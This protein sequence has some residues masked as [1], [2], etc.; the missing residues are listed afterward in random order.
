MKILSLVI[1]L[2]TL[3]LS[4]YAQNTY[5]GEVKRIIDGDTFEILLDIKHFGIYYKH[6]FRVKNF[7]APETFRPMN[8]AERTHGK[9]ATALAKV[10]LENKVIKVTVFNDYTYARLLCHIAL[11][12]GKDFALTMKEAGMQKKVSYTQKEITDHQK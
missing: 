12:D 5:S 4:T 11:P 7:D 6:I 8:E 1:F 3:F 2:F 10:L 9:Q